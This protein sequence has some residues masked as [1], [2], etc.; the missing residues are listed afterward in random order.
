[1][2]KQV[3]KENK[4]EKNIQVRF[5]AEEYE[6]LREKALKEKRTLSGLIRVKALKYLRKL[7]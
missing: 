3:A 4:L 6:L 2:S 7:T 5:T 1:M